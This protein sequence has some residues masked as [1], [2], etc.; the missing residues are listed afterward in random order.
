MPVKQVDHL[1]LPLIEVQWT[2][3]ILFLEETTGPKWEKIDI[4]ERARLA[5]STL[6]E[7][8][9]QKQYLSEQPSNILPWIRMLS[10]KWKLNYSKM[11]NTLI[12]FFLI[13]HGI[14]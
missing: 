11:L 9:F 1:K 7:V 10:G 3:K 5:I 8:I 6:T 13:Q 14:F 2:T 12:T 4:A